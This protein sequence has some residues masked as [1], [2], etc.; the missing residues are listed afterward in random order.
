VSWLTEHEVVEYQ[1]GFSLPNGP[2]SS[3]VFR[4]TVD[5]DDPR[6]STPMVRDGHDHGRPTAPTVG[7][8]RPPN[9]NASRSNRGDG[10]PSVAAPSP[11]EETPPALRARAAGLRRTAASLPPGADRDGYLEMASDL[12]DRASLMASTHPAVAAG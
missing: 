11:A 2:R 9:E 5:A 7:R 12:E 8:R 4:L 6:S 10:C 3:S 1:A